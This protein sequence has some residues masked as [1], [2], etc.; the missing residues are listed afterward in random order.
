MIILA[1][2]VRELRAWASVRIAQCMQLE[3]TDPSAARERRV[4][5]VVIR[6]LDGDSR[7]VGAPVSMAEAAIA[8]PVTPGVVCKCG[9]P[10]AT[11]DDLERWN[12]ETPD[13]RAANGRWAKALC[14]SIGTTCNM[15]A[16]ET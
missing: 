9:R 15:I 12:K 13:Q 6:R 10:R 8:M 4:L 16:K 5:Q 3:R 2:R 1:E 11:V 7:E 14:W